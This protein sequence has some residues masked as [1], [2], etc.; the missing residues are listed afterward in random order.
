MHEAVMTEFGDSQAD[1]TIGTEASREAAVPADADIPLGMA[2]D[3]ISLAEY[4]P[5]P[6]VVEA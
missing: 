2:Q 3:D 6:Q 4:M 1:A 5:H